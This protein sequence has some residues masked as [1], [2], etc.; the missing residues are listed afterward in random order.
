MTNIEKYVNLIERAN[1]PKDPKLYYVDNFGGNPHLRLKFPSYE[2]FK[3]ITNKVDN[4]LAAA[5]ATTTTTTT[6]TA[7]T[8]ANRSSASATAN[9]TITATTATIPGIYAGFENLKHIKFNGF[10]LI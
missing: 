5:A 10:D 9:G 2:A 7:A 8:S 6:V 3:G 1:T 4:K